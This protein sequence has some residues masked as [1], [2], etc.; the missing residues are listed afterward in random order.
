MSKAGGSSSKQVRERTNW[1]IHM[2]YIRQDYDKCLT[3]IEDTL[4]ECK[5]MAEC[6]L[7]PA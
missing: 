2:L 5:G 1:L 7:R 3:T 4:K 6:A